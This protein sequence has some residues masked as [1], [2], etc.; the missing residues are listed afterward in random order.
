MTL[1]SPTMSHQGSK[2]LSWAA[3]AVLSLHG[4]AGQI[5]SSKPVAIADAV[6]GTDYD[7]DY[8]VDAPSNYGPYA[9]EDGYGL[10]DRFDVGGLSTSFDNIDE[11]FAELFGDLQDLADGG[12]TGDGTSFGAIDLGNLGDLGGLGDNIQSIIGQLL[13][14]LNNLN[15]TDIISN[16]NAQV[17]PVVDAARACASSQLGGPAQACLS[18]LVAGVRDRYGDMDF[19]QDDMDGPDGGIFSRGRNLRHIAGAR[20]K[21][22]PDMFVDE[23]A[24]CTEACSSLL[25]NVTASCPDLANLLNVTSA[26]AFCSDA[27]LPAD[28][29]AAPTDAGT[30]DVL[31]PLPDK[32]APEATV[33]EQPALIPIVEP[34]DIGAETGENGNFVAGQ[35]SAGSLSIGVGGGLAWLSMLLLVLG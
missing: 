17:Q 33:E 34:A 35:A 22:G 8:A 25:S 11:L 23:T 28:V 7:Y 15:I 14:E 16:V 29:T 2:H 24:L 18:S 4:V 30:Q 31:Q 6:A 9:Y 10:V 21:F 32:D 20:G 27:V 12:F 26:Q 5:D 13:G 19:D 1:E 3:L